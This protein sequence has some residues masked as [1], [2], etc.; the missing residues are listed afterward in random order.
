MS[1]LGE[2]SPGRTRFLEGLQD[3]IALGCEVLP[4]QGEDILG[5]PI[6]WFLEQ[7]VGS[8]DYGAIGGGAGGRIK[9]FFS[10]GHETPV[11]LETVLWRRVYNDSLDAEKELP[12]GM[13]GRFVEGYKPRTAEAIFKISRDEI[14]TRAKALLERSTSIGNFGETEIRAEAGSKDRRV[15]AFRATELGLSFSRAIVL[16][17]GKTIQVGE[18]LDLLEALGD[19]AAAAGCIVAGAMAREGIERV[20]VGNGIV[21]LVEHGGADVAAIRGSITD[22]AQWGRERG[23]TALGLNKNRWPMPPF[24]HRGVARK[25]DKRQRVEIAD[26]RFMIRHRFTKEAVTMGPERRRLVLERAVEEGRRRGEDDDV[27]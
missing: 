20:V 24:L 27:L 7:K 17:T 4:D 16:E 3:V 9:Q 18:I 21:I 12:S 8:V 22:M 6:A 10:I 19:E 1:G 13:F 25:L 26:G 5:K 15:A 23:M 2:K 14:E 11:A